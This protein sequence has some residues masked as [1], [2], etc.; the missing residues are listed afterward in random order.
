M[1][2]ALEPR[3][4]PSR[5]M[6]YAAPLIAAAMMLSSGLIVF[7]ALGQD[8]GDRV[9]RVFRRAAGRSVRLG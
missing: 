2:L 9:P 6:A 5:Q 7:T 3:A 1:Q 4:A 8:P